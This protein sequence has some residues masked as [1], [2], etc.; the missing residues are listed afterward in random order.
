MAELVHPS[1]IKITYNSFFL[2]NSCNTYSP[3]HITRVNNM[4]FLN[5]LAELVYPSRI[6]I[7]YILFLLKKFMYHL[8]T[9]TYSRVNNLLFLNDVAELVHP[10]FFFFIWMAWPNW[11]EITPVVFHDALFSAL[12]CPSFRH[13]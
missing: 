12:A 6:K 1:R 3:R 5:D 7:T 10:S 4:L 11:K 8:F 9:L 13:G 2:K